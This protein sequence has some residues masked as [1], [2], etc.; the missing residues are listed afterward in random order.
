MTAHRVVIAALGMLAAL[1]L[2][3]ALGAACTPFAAEPPAEPTADGGIADAPVA[4]PDASIDAADAA[5]L[6]DA[7]ADGALQPPCGNYLGEVAAWSGKVNVHRA[8][9]EAWVVDG[10]C[11][12]GANDVTIAYCQKFWN[13][14]T[15]LR[16][17]P[18]SLEVKPFRTSGG[19]AP[20]CG[21]PDK[22]PF[23]GD[24]QYACC[25]P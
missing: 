20:D 11:H 14:T 1:P 25:G 15:S 19:K 13:L 6:L 7:T 23:P 4:P 17:V 21:G 22:L 2:A 16:E 12:S 24:K 10:D 5:V 8:P 18:V 9:G 3:L